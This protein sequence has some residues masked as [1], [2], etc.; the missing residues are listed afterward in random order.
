MNYRLNNLNTYIF[1]TKASIIL[2]LTVFYANA[3]DA[4]PIIHKYHTVY[5]NIL[6]FIALL[7]H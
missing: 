2:S 7:K 4:S 1:A 5:E 6:L 3:F